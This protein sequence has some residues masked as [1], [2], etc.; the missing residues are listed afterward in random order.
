M[1]S[2][3]SHFPG[4]QNT[5]AFLLG[6]ITPEEVYRIWIDEGTDREGIV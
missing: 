3:E 6:M 4:K 5:L 2:N 1:K